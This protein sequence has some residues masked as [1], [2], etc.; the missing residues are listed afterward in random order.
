MSFSSYTMSITILLIYYHIKIGG[1]ETKR[2]Y[3]RKGTDKDYLE[4]LIC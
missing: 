2:V 1:S 4:E 3:H